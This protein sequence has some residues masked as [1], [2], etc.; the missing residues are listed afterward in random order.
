MIWFVKLHTNIQQ[1]QKAK[2]DYHMLR[3]DQ[4]FCES[5]TCIQ[6]MIWFVKLHTNIQQDQKAKLDYH[7]SLL[8][9]NMAGEEGVGDLRF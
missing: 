9:A 1:D 8:F 4:A 5:Y 6:L 3:E 2:L 7:M